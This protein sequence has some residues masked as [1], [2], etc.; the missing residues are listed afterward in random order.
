MKEFFGVVLFILI[1]VGIFCGLILVVTYTVS[2]PICLHTLDK[3]GV[4]GTWGFWE[5]CM[6][7]TEDF[8]VIP[9]DQYMFV[10]TGK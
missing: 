2:R 3:M 6:V 10:L 4:D 7:D 8:G 9:L 1:V 5:D